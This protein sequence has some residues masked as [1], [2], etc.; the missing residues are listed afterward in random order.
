MIV[1]IFSDNNLGYVIAKNPNSP[2]KAV[3]IRKGAAIGWFDP[4]K[5]Y[6]YT[7]RFVDGQDEVSFPQHRDDN[8]EYL[9]PTRYCSAM[10]A[11]SL[12]SEFTPKVVDLSKD[13]YSAR[14]QV[15]SLHVKS[16]TRRTLSHYFPSLAFTCLGYEDYH[17]MTVDQSSVEKALRDVKSALLFIMLDTEYFYADDAFISKYA[18]IVAETPYFV[19]YLFKTNLL[20]SKN[21]FNQFCPII[22]DQDHVFVHG[23]L[24]DNR[25][26]FVNDHIGKRVVDVGCG[27]G[28]Y[29]KRFGKNTESYVAYDIDSEQLETCQKIIDKR[30]LSGCHVVSSLTESWVGDYDGD[31]FDTVL[32]IEVIE[33]MD[34][35]KVQSF[36][37]AYACLFPDATFLVTTPDSRFNE[38]YPV[39]SRHD[40]HMW[41]KSPEEVEPLLRSVFGTV[42][43]VPIGDSVF[44]VTPT[45]GYVCHA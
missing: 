7:I 22:A 44:G 21:A 11:L 38:H 6:K 37:Q 13:T 25:L 23:G 31:P 45:Q 41:E 26:S 12:L 1:K 35:D 29:L 19:R 17:V 8:Y 36:L 39:Q 4:G 16:R 10:C 18:K 24:N 20:K 5:P 33:H 30:E 2:P 15:T 42:Q 40:D 3:K 34:F 9:S 27:E 32:M 28:T 14:I 43:Y